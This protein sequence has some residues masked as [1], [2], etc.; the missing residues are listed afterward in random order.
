ML[1]VDIRGNAKIN[2][3]VK[4]HCLSSSNLN[5]FNLNFGS[6]TTIETSLYLK[7]CEG[8]NLQLNEIKQFGT[9]ITG[10]AIPLQA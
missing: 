2:S 8:S 4:F 5:S 7:E 3:A 10:E 1:R 9:K 6:I